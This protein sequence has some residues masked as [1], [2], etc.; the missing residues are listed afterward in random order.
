MR[1]NLTV[2]HHIDYILL[3][4]NQI[5]KEFYY[6]VKNYRFGLLFISFL[7]IGFIIRLEIDI[8]W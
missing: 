6:S 5:Y 8:N 2:F 3:I 1:L 7:I 4:L